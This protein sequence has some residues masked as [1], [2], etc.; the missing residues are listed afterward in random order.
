MYSLILEDL[1]CNW[2]ASH[3]FDYVSCMHHPAQ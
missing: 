1:K 3:V 2:E